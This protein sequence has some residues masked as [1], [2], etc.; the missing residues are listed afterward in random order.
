M[1]TSLARPIAAAHAAT[2]GTR[3]AS[4]IPKKAISTAVVLALLTLWAVATT[5]GWV[6]PLFLPSPQQVLEQTFVVMRDV[7]RPLLHDARTALLPFAYGRL[8]GAHRVVPE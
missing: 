8:P 4:P 7:C 6:S 5:Y 1:S 3:S 2:P